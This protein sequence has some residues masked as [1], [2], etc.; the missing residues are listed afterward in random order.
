MKARLSPPLLRATPIHGFALL[1][2]LISL[3]LACNPTL[4]LY[5]AEQRRVCNF[6]CFALGCPSLHCAS[7][8]FS[9]ACS[10]SFTSH[11]MGNDRNSALTCPPLPSPESSSKATVQLS[12]P[13][14]ASWPALSQHSR[15]RCVQPLGYREL[16][17]TAPKKHP[18]HRSCR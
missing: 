5:A 17:Y 10:W 1:H 15:D 2:L 6:G 7:R 18:A 14:S 16:S 13:G 11:A 9:S 3:E 8:C 4:G 12:A